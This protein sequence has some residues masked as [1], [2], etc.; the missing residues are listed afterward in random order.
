MNRTQHA[1]HR[2]QLLEAWQSARKATVEAKQKAREAE[3]HFNNCT[4]IERAA[5]LALKDAE[6]YEKFSPTGEWV[7]SQTVHPITKEETQ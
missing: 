6:I 5:W 1:K 4:D 7:Y 2:Q 3:S